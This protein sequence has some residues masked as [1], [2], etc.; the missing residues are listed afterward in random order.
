MYKPFLST[1]KKIKLLLLLLFLTSNLLSQDQ[2]AEIIFNDGDILEGYGMITKNH[3]IKFRV[4]LEDKPDTWTSLMVKGITF[5]GFEMSKTFE[6]VKTNR[7][8]KPVLLEVISFGKATLYQESFNFSSSFFDGNMMNRYHHSKEILYVKREDEEV[9]TRLSGNFK[10]L[11]KEY[12]K[13]CDVIQ[14]MINTNEFRK[15]SKEEIIDE[16]NIYCSD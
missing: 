9:A 1:M 12:F 16:Y 14:E 10:K 13:D 4:S 8:Q 6:Y 5:Y 15:Y 2:K 11:I 3:K 7:K